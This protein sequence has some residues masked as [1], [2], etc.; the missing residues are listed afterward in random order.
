MIGPFKS[1]SG[2]FR[3]VHIAIDKFS[4]WI[5]YKPLITATIKKVADLIEEIV[6]HFSLPN[7]TSPT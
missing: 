7:S 5:E 3:Y 6:H 1:A 2:G 4:K